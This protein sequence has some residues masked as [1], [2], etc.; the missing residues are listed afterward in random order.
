M[1]ARIIVPGWGGAFLDLDVYCNI[2]IYRQVLP[3]QFDLCS[4]PPVEQQYIRDDTKHDG[5]TS[6]AQS[7]VTP[8]LA[9]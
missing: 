5:C 1:F 4:Q 7:A 8:H 9:N 2:Y 6:S 3:S